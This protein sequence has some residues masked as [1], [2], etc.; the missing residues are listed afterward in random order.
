MVRWI[1]LALSSGGLND[2]DVAVKVFEMKKIYQLYAQVSRLIPLPVS[3]T[4]I[5]YRPGHLKGKV[6]PRT[7]REGPEGSGGVDLLFL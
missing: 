2:V 4:P 3:E 6:H 7:V 5:F 1:V